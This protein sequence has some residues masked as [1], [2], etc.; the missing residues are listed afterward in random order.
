MFHTYDNRKKA[1]SPP[2]K[3]A[4]ED[5]SSL[6]ALRTG[7]APAQEQMGHRVDMPEAMREKMENAFG[8]DISA[9]KL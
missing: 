8:A 4:A 7:A 1:G 2:N 9:V 6:E 3:E 5:A